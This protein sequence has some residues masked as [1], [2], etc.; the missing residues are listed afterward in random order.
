MGSREPSVWDYAPRAHRTEKPAPRLRP[1]SG[2]HHRGRRASRAARRARCAGRASTPTSPQAHPTCQ[3]R[4]TAAAID[5][6]SRDRERCVRSGRTADRTGGTGPPFATGTRA[7]LG[8]LPRHRSRMAACSGSEMR[9]RPVVAM[10]DGAAPAP[11]RA[12]ACSPSDSSNRSVS[13]R[14]SAVASA[15]AGGPACT[16]THSQPTRRTHARAAP[17][18]W[19][20]RQRQRQRMH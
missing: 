8:V 16:T 4:A 7:H 2:A 20:Q 19:P 9:A 18:R 14:R 15:C 12:C 6:G 11:P 13:T 1:T 5:R 3:S 10:S 17:Q